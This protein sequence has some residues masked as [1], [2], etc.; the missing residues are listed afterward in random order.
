MNK[1]L[2][3]SIAAIAIIGGSIAISNSLSKSE[4]GSASNVSVVDGKQYIDITAKGGYSPR[5]TFAQAN[6]PTILKIDTNGTFDCSAAVKIPS[7]NYY[8]ILPPSGTSEVE[9]P[10]QQPGSKIQGLC[11]MGMYNFSITFN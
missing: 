7:L 11:V 6:V 3:S 5:N 2:F 1:V 8:T 10:P 9:I 4:A